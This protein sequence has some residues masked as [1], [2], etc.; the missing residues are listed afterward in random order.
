MT[1]QVPVNARGGSG[2]PLARAVSSRNE[3]VQGGGALCSDEG[4][5]FG[6]GN[7]P[8]LIQQV[9]GVRE[10]LHVVHGDT[11]RA[12]VGGASGCVFGVVAVGV[13]EF[14]DA[15]L[16]DGVGAGAGASGVV[17]GL[18]AHVHAGAG[19]VGSRGAGGGEGVSFGV[20][21]ACASVVAHVQQVPVRIGNNGADEGVRATD[22]LTCRLQRQGHGFCV[23]ERLLGVGQLEG[24]CGG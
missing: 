13:V 24:A 14:A 15:C 6:G 3:P 7:D 11:L 23:A 2:N 19:E 17:A 5:A 10:L 18:E 4:A 12:Q 9:G 8:A 1:N 21:G 20:R 22:A 16:G